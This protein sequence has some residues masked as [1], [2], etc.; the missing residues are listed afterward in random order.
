MLLVTGATGFIG[1]SLLPRLTESG[2]PV[3]CLV[4]DPR[5]LGAERVRVQ[6]ALGELT[7]H[8]ALR[9]AVRGVRTVI[10]LGAGAG[11]QPRATVEELGSIATWRLVEAAERAGVER[12][13]FFS[14]LGAGPDAPTRLLRDKALAED[15]VASANLATT[16][17]ALSLVMGSGDELQRSVEALARLPL[18]P[19]SGNGRGTYEPCWVDDV[20]SATEATLDR[21]PASGHER[22]ELAGPERLRG[23]Q[24][25]R[26]E[27]NAAAARRLIV[28][29][30]PRTVS[31]AL[32]AL[33]A[34]PGLPKAWDPEAF[35]GAEMVSADG[36][37]G[38]R[39]LG[40]N[41]RSA[42]EI[43]GLA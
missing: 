4:R 27:L 2:V 19:L 6:I 9:N 40:V 31:R 33:G 8:R 12:L 28:P 16:T 17:L 14:A 29:A 15:A 41:P 32:R 43:L 20:V 30:P 10:H 1:S 35:L 38:F 34:G 11:D 37:A 23:R 26:L 22:I 7:D 13:I 42:A 3:R 21:A 36:S 18:F 5:R 25:A 24:L 39:E